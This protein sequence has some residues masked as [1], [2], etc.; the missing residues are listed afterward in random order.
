MAEATSDSGGNKLIYIGI[1]V[2]VLIGAGVGIYFMTKKKGEVP[3][4]SSLASSSS[5]PASSSSA[6]KSGNDYVSSEAIAKRNGASYK[7]WQDLGLNQADREKD[8]KDPIKM[9]KW[10][11]YGAYWG[12]IDSNLGSVATNEP[13]VSAF[14]KGMNL[15]LQKDYVAIFK[16]FIQQYIDN[17]ARKNHWEVEVGEFLK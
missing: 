14:L 2:V 8:K 4:P 6:P 12:S 11:Q 13:L 17:P 9:G 3:S 10:S 7:G 15:S 5:A 1:G 16:P